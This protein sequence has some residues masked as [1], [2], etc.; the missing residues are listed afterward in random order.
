MTM[1]VKRWGY[2]MTKYVKPKDIDDIKKE[3]SST[4][5]ALRLFNRWLELEKMNEYRIYRNLE[6]SDLESLIDTFKK[7]ELFE[8]LYFSVIEGL[9]NSENYYVTY[10]SDDRRLESFD[11]LGKTDLL[12]KFIKEVIQND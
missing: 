7:S 3:Y 9:Y 10:N 11:S 4:E 12:S 2:K 1:S 6:K 5:K 8:V